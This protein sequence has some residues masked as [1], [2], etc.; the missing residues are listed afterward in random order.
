MVTLGLPH[1]N[2]LFTEGAHSLSSTVGTQI[3]VFQSISLC[4]CG[5]CILLCV[6][7]KRG[8]NIYMKIGTP[9]E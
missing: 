2:A 5:D 6:K 4:F 7:G 8:K 9:E 3:F 1:E